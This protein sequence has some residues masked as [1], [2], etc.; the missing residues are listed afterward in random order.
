MNERASVTLL[1]MMAA[2]RRRRTDAAEHSVLPKL[3]RAPDFDTCNFYTEAV[4]P[5][6][7][8]KRVLLRRL[9]FIDVNRTRYVSV[10]FYPSRD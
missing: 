2:A 9:F 1:S 6:F 4:N 5:M 3:V 10:G 7:D 8:P